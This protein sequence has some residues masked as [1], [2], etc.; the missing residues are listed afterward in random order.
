LEAKYIL[1]T[2]E[3]WI[4]EIIQLSPTCVYKVMDLYDRNNARI[5]C[6]FFR[7][8]SAVELIQPVI[9]SRISEVMLLFLPDF[10]LDNSIKVLNWSPKKS[11]KRHSYYYSIDCRRRKP[12]YVPGKNM[13]SWI[14]KLQSHFRFYQQVFCW[15]GGKQTPQKIDIFQGGNTVLQVYVSRESKLY[16]FRKIK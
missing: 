1:K 3:V 7:L 8:T 11:S 16:S 4:F 5:A 9:S 10:V 2:N 15:G 6:L 13:L 12:E 14:G